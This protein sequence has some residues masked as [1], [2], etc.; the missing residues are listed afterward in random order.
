MNHCETCKHWRKV[1]DAPGIDPP[2][3][4]GGYCTSGKFEEY[5]GALSYESDNVVYPYMEGARYWWTG[6]KFGCVH[7]DPIPK[8]RK[9]SP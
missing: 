7:H 2:E 9:P 5:G 4:T 6:P 8:R 1:P 3:S